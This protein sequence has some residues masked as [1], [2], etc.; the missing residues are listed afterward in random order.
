MFKELI[1]H[2]LTESVT[3]RDFSLGAPAK[4]LK[5]STGEMMT[6]AQRAALHQRLLAELSVVQDG[7]RKDLLMTG[8]VC[9]FWKGHSSRHTFAAE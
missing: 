2:Y 4:D 9:I 5:R 8:F 1:D 3:D 7:T 6:P